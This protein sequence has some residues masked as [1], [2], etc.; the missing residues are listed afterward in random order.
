MNALITGGTGFVGS[1]LTEEL[2]RRGWTVRIL[3]KDAMYGGDLA[4][5][6]VIADLRDERALAPLLADAEYIFHVAGVTRARRI[7]D[8]YDG[9][10]LATRSLL[11]ACGR[12]CRALER[13]VFVS[14]LTAVGPRT[15]AAEVDERSPYHPVSHYGRS[16]MLAELEVL[17]MHRKLPVTVVRP[18]AIYG[19]RDRDLLRYF[20]LIRRGIQPLLGE[21]GHEL[22]LVHVSDVVDG[23]V[24]AAEH[25]AALGRVFHIGSADNYSC[26]TI[27]GAIAETQ[28]MHP[29][30]FYLPEALVYLAG[31]A[32]ECTGRLLDREVF[33]NT[34]KV[35]ETVQKAWTCSIERARAWIG[36]QP[37]IELAPGIRATYE[38][39]RGNAWM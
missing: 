17:A 32:G 21:P 4:A 14:S 9:N 22:N 28:G 36:Y 16:K 31:L 30:V 12:H 25:P 2:L 37:R 24:R 15:G 6:I 7:T 23:I 38:W 35:R 13:L 5:E 26:E 3:A 29:I 11:K 34:Q 27:C 10:Y 8:Y 18:S 39:Y 33:L 19:P 1:H 20:R